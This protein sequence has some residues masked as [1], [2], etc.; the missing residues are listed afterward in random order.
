MPLEDIY[1][2]WKNHLLPSRALKDEVK[3]IYTKR[4][5]I[6]NEC[7]SHSKNHFSI[8]PDA[9]CTICGCTLIAKTK[10][11]SCKC[12]IDKWTSEVE[13]QLEDTIKK[14]L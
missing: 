14:H 13:E 12:P 4:I 9:H 2:G 1:D 7:P 5:A 8:R 11:L 6:C 10:C 3:S